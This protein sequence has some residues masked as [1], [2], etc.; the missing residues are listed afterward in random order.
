MPRHTHLLWIPTWNHGKCNKPRVYTHSVWS[1]TRQKGTRLSGAE[2]HGSDLPVVNQTV[3]AESNGMFQNGNQTGIKRES[4]GM[5]QKHYK[6]IDIVMHNNILCITIYYVM[7]TTKH[8]NIL[9]Q[10]AHWITYRLLINLYIFTCEYIYIWIMNYII[11]N[12]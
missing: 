8:N 6:S 4:N 10:L 12:I 3:P 7:H 5:C 9:C 2:R 1:W 11:L